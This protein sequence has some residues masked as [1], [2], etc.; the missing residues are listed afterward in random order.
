MNINREATYAV[1]LGG[2]HGTRLWPL[3]RKNCPKQFLNITGE[4]ELIRVTYQRLEKILP[5]ENIF[6]ITVAEQEQMV[7]ECIPSLLSDHVIIE[8]VKRG[9]GPC[10]VLAAQRISTR[11]TDATMLVVPADH[12]VSPLADYLEALTVACCIASEKQHLVTIGLTPASASSAYGYIKCGET[13]R[14]PALG[15][16]VYGARQF[17]E[18][19]DVASAEKL[20]DA[21]GF[22]WNTGTFAW[23]INTFFSALQ[24]YAPELFAGFVRLKESPGSGITGAYSAFENISIDYALMER[25]QNVAVVSALFQRVDVG[26]L[27]SLSLVLPGD[28]NGNTASGNFAQVDSRDN[29]VY[30]PKHLTALVGMENVVVIVTDDV[31]LVCPKKQTQRVRALVE[32]LK[33]PETIQYL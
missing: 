30:S 12:L 8:P 6:V 7:R 2:G 4:G 11:A 13:I 15:L 23:N 19:P 20:I 21:G 32:N 16:R 31:V 18:K 10:L 3:S 25:A 9:T 22:L 28:S 14:P 17:I 29:V 1:I 33:K 27:S 26:D 24:N 5:V